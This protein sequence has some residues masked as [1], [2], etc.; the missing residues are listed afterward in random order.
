MVYVLIIT[1]FAAFFLFSPSNLEDQKHQELTRR[2]GFKF[3]TLTFDPLVAEMEKLAEERELGSRESAIAEGNH[4]VPHAYGHYYD[5]GR[6]NISLRLLVLFPLLDH[7]PKDGGISY[8]E[9]SDWIT[10]QAIERL[11]YRT[12]KQLAFYDKNGDGAISFHEYLPKFTEE[13]IAR[14]ETGYGEAGWWS[15]QFTNA[16]VDQNGLLNFD[17]LKE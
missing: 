13:D 11:N 5:E 7:S 6:L 8:E 15:K 1:A 12:R 14:N 9:L 4:Q 16:D 2:L 17:E 10:G 3:R